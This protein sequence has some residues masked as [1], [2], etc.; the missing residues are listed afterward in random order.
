MIS[1]QIRPI[2]AQFFCVIDPNFLPNNLNTDF[3]NISSKCWELT[4]GFDLGFDLKSGS[5]LLFAKLNEC[6]AQTKFSSFFS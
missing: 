3:R 6:L 5:E 4:H 1:G 2:F